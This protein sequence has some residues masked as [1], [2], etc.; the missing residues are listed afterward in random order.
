ML[1]SNSFWNVKNKNNEIKN[2]KVN[3]VANKICEVVAPV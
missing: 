1:M 2:I 3:P